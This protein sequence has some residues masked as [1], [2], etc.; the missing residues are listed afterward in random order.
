MKPIL[1][2]ACLLAAVSAPAQPLQP[3]PAYHKFFPH[4]QCSKEA[5]RLAGDGYSIMRAH[6]L[7]KNTRYLTIIDFTKASN[8]QRFFVLDLVAQKLALASITAHGVGSDP[9]STTRPYRFSNR[10]GSRMSSIGFYITGAIY[11][12]HRPEDS[13]GLC[14]FGMDKGFNDSAAVREIVVHYG[15]TEYK[16]HVYVTD[17]GAARSFGCPALPI[18]SNTKIISLIKEGSCL[19]IYS[20][21]DPSYPKKS[22]VLHDRLKGKII[23]QGPPPNNCACQLEVK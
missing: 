5:F 8:Q 6:G 7:L 1:L 21:K 9:D 2:I 16:G 10:D 19:F 22:T 17:S 18:S 12:N 20:D 14:L 15:A 23:Q 11:T 13:L 4:S 3:F